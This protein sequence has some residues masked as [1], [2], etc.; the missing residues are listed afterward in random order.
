MPRKELIHYREVRKRWAD[1]ALD[2]LNKGIELSP[3][4]LGKKINVHQ[5]QMNRMIRYAQFES[6]SKEAPTVDMIIELCL[7][8]DYSIEW[9][10]SGLGD[11]RLRES[12][13]D[14]LKRY[15]KTIK[16]V[17]KLVNN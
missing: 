16:G 8:Y 9:V 11:M 10:M 15:E 5:T 6:D 14:K 13:L 17:Q 2:I 3:A 4:E 1:V 12:Q 7:Q